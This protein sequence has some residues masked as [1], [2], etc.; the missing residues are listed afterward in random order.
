MTTVFGL[1]HPTLSG[2]METEAPL[3][4]FLREVFLL[5]PK[6]WASHKAY[7]L[8]HCMTRSQPFVFLKYWQIQHHIHMSMAYEAVGSAEMAS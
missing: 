6:H 4:S 1:A 5:T 2:G 7:Q 3:Y 8:C